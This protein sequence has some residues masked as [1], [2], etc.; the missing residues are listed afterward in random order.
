MLS[1]LTCFNLIFPVGTSSKWVNI[2]GSQHSLEVKTV[3]NVRKHVK[4]AELHF[5]QTKREN[6]K[7]DYD[8]LCSEMDL[9]LDRAFEDRQNGRGTGQLCNRNQELQK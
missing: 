2:K 6:L 5:H 8:F 9:V 4:E 3:S 7:S 1:A